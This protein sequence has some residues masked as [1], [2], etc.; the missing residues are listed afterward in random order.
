MVLET[1]I[2]H[3]HNVHPSADMMHHSSTME[4]VETDFFDE[5]ESFV[6]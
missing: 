4:I 2:E 5:E 1:E 6:F 3:M